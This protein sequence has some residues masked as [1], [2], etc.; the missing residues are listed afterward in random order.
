MVMMPNFIRIPNLALVWS[1]DLGVGTYGPFKVISGSKSR[2]T[3]W[4]GYFIM[5]IHDIHIKR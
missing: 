5:N 3:D 2:K 1:F 4:F